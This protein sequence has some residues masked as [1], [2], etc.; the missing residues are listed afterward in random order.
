MRKFFLYSLLIS[1]LLYTSA[2]NDDDPVNNPI[3]LSASLENIGTDVILA[4][5]GNLH[6]KTEQL[7]TALSALRLTPDD[8]QLTN[9]R[10]AWRDARQPWEQSEGFLF[11]P[12]D[13][14]GIDPAIDSWPVNETDLDA[15]LNSGTPLTKSY[16]DGLDG[17]LK[18]FHTIE[19]LLFGL[20][21]N[22]TVAQFTAREFEY[23]DACSQSLSGSTHQLYLSWDPTGED[24]IANLLN[25]GNTNLSIYQS[26]KS[27]LEEI[28]NGLIVIADEVGNGKINDPLV[29][30]DL[31][32]EESRFSANSKQDFAD[33]IRSIEN[34][35]LGSYENASGDGITTI[36]KSVNESLDAQIR[37][38]ISAA[39]SAIESIEGTFTTAIFNA[40]A[41]VQQAQTKVRDLQET[42]ESQLLPLINSL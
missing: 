34:I 12:V 25:A 20:D 24:Y 22:K 13:Q 38:D 19:Y 8:A 33:N 16:I 23:L 36:V 2:C 41:S 30:Q 4:T 29:Q 5:Y 40:T 11:G 32:L 18:G 37:N 17:T 9:A 35:Y 21:G 39:I 6:S 27:A 31:T 1:S 42:L 10:Q 26:E 14:Q 15:V 3:D 7:H 28:V